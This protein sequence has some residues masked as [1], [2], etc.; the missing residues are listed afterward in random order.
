[1]KLVQWFLAA[2]LLVFAG[3]LFGGNPP[4][5]NSAH[6]GICDT[7]KG[8]T[9][10]LFGLCVAYCE[11]NDKDTFGKTKVLRNYNH[12][13]V[14]GVDPEMPCIKQVECPCFTFDQVS[15]I[16][17]RVPEADTSWCINGP[18]PSSYTYQDLQVLIGEPPDDPWQEWEART[19]DSIGSEEVGCE[20]RDVSWDGES[21]E[22]T[23]VEWTAS[24]NDQSREFLQQCIDIMDAIWIVY[25]LPYDSEA[26]SCK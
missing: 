2:F 20:Y 25:E 22:E 15:A 9:P 24:A 23:L 12:K 4:K 19:W 13:R 21:S 26:V 18:N 5:M 11:A 10:G 3:S 16:A 17:D 8:G 7:L 1:M 6:S 14:K